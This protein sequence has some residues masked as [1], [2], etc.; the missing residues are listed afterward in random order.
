MT[1]LVYVW[2]GAKLPAWARLSLQLAK[3]TSG[4]EVVLLCN[5]SIGLVHGVARQYYI[6]DFYIQPQILLDSY[7]LAR[8]DFRRGFLI[9]T[10]ERFF[11]L[12]QFLSKYSI[13]SIFHAE[14][15]NMVFNIS[16]LAD[17]L[18]QIGYGLFCPRDAVNRGIASL[19]YINNPDSLKEFTDLALEKLEIDTNDMELLGE[20]LKKSKNYYSLPTEASVSLI[21]DSQSLDHVSEELT[22]GIFD[23]AAIGQFLFGIDPRNCNGL[24]Y[25]GFENENKGCNLWKLRFSIDL[26]HGRASISQNDGKNITNLYNIHVHSKLFNQLLINGRINEII[27]RIHNGQKTMMSLNVLSNPL[28]Q[29]FLKRL[30]FII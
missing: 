29:L 16:L 27:H 8:A 1:S 10:T 2:V 24:L 14:L 18:N 17:K 3:K 25:N 19:I 26:Q 6:E 30:G 5:R 22:E 11:I 4:L 28:L 9:K 20:C 15:D 12:H 23:A 13:H 7:K 21:E